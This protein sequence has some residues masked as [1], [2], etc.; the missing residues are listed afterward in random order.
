MIVLDVTDPAQPKVAVEEEIDRTVVSFAVFDNV[1]FCRGK[2]A[3]E[4]YE[5]SALPMMR[6]VSV[7][8]G[9][10]GGS[11]LI[12]DGSGKRL[13]LSGWDKGFDI[14]DFSDLEKPIYVSGCGCEYHS[15][16]D[17]WSDRNNVKSYGI[18]QME[19]RGDFLIAIA[20][21]CNVRKHREA[22]LIYDVQ[23]LEEPRL[24]SRISTSP[25][26][27]HAMAVSG[28]YAFAG[29]YEKIL[30]ID[31][32]Q[33]EEPEIVGEIELRG[34][35]ANFFFS[36]EDRLYVSGSLLLSPDRDRFIGV[37]DTSNPVHPKSIGGTSLPIASGYDITLREDIAY[38]ACAEGLA[39]VSVRNPKA[40]ELL[41]LHRTTRPGVEFWGIEVF[42]L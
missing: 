23:R 16:D 31:I 12:V 8:E 5:L 20:M 13:F 35:C 10:V 26:R 25:I 34:V 11:T 29:G 42:L 33:P 28:D 40:P 22:L 19:K 30:S 17:E 6:K 21:E 9:T 1:L 14:V 37:V 36:R 38:I 27:T 15:D 41:S 3:L 4:I 7:L 2:G 32:K 39:I 18:T 24:L